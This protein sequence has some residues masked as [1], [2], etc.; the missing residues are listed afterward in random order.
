MDDTICAVATGLGNN[1]IS[2]IRVSGNEAI[3]I[4]NQMFKEKYMVIYMIMKKY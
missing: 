4:V 1:A 2:I 3:T